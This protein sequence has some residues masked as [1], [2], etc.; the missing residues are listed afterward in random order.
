MRV[1]DVIHEET[2]ER[3][4]GSRDQKY[5]DNIQLNPVRSQTKTEDRAQKHVPSIDYTE[6]KNVKDETTLA[7][8]RDMKHL[9]MVSSSL[10]SLK[11]INVDA[12]NADITFSQ[13]N[14]QEND[15]IF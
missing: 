4:R 7:V 2:E 6:I 3:E 1:E 9:L 12:L 15:S 11:G 5:R 8:P 14:E 10:G 13:Q